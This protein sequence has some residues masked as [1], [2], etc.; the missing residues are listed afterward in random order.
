[1]PTCRGDDPLW[2]FNLRARAPFILS[3]A[4]LG[5][6]DP[7]ARGILVGLF[8]I[9]VG[10]VLRY[11]RTIR[12]WRNRSNASFSPFMRFR[13]RALAA[14]RRFFRT[15]VGTPL[16]RLDLLLFA[17]AATVTGMS[18]SE[19][20]LLLLQLLPLLSSDV[21]LCRSCRLC[22]SA[23]ASGLPLPLLLVSVQMEKSCCCCRKLSLFVTGSKDS[24]L[25]PLGVG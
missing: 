17:G 10:C 19:P 2:R 20:A 9:S 24:A 8:G 14:R 6:T 11:A 12:Y 18:H 13:S 7:P 21:R 1:M 25:L 22:G 4:A 15:T 23:S 3:D 5:P 16:P